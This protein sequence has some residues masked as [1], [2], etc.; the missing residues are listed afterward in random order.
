MGNV[1]KFTK[2]FGVFNQVG[3]QQRRLVRNFGI[4]GVIVI[5]TAMITMYYY[6]NRLVN[7]LSSHLIDENTFSTKQRLYLFFVPLRKNLHVVQRQLQSFDIEDSEVDKELY[8]LVKPFMELYPQIKGFS[9]SDEAGNNHFKLFRKDGGFITRL[10][11]SEEWGRNKAQWRRWKDGQVVE[12]W[13]RYT[14]YESTTWPWFRGA[15]DV[16]PGKAYWSDPYMLYVTNVPAITVSSSWR[17]PDSGALFV[18]SFDVHLSDISRFTMTLRP[19]EN[20]KVLV[21]SDD[22]RIMGLPWDERFTDDRSIDGALL[23]KISKLNFPVLEA[24][25]NQWADKGRTEQIFSFA[26]NDENWWVGFKSHKFDDKREFWVG[27]FIPESDFIRGGTI[28]RNIMIGIIMI[29]GVLIGAFMFLK[30]TLSVRRRLQKTMSRIGQPLGQYKLKY[31]IGDGGNGA[32]Y[33]AQHAMLRRPTAIKLMHPEFAQSESAK[34]RFE[35]E[36]QI[37]SCL[38]HPNTVAVYDYGITPDGTLYYAM[39]FLSGINLEDLVLNKGAVNTA[40]VIYILQQICA[41]LDEAHSK[42]MIHRDIKPANIM[43]CERGGMYDRVKVLDFGLVKELNVKGPELTQLNTLVGTPFYMAP[44][45]I[46]TPD[47]VSP[48]SDLYALGAVAYYLLTGHKVFEGNSSVEICASH[49]HDLPETPSDRLGQAIPQD[50]ER[51]ILQC[52]EKEPEKRPESAIALANSLAE[53]TVPTWTKKQARD[54]WSEHEVLL[55]QP[56]EQQDNQ[57]LS[58][59][60]VLVNIEKRGTTINEIA[61]GADNQR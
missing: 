37:M 4:L 18:S 17:K 19:S 48:Q 38:T 26:S 53:C 58:N 13:L 30:Y 40:R 36:V 50:L 32:V 27:V 8:T 54:W 14:D 34:A 61:A 44:E 23:A 35:H 15:L 56:V 6:D 41:S 10:V 51:L 45:T 16:D 22:G 25:Y 3:R 21:L 39:E 52:L 59:T 20:G 9:L 24:A 43:L 60:Q 29:L 5:S 46:T 49:L 57:A 55:P 33:R 31:K 28:E 47:R 11:N 12:S 2:A 42:D 7:A 1:K